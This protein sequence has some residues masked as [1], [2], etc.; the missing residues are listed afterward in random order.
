ML[1]RRVPQSG[2]PEPRHRWPPDGELTPQ[3][4]ADAAPPAGDEILPQPE[5]YPGGDDA[6]IAGNGDLRGRVTT[7][8]TVA[9]ANGTSG[10]GVAGAGRTSCDP[11]VPPSGAPQ[12]P[13]PA[14]DPSDPPA[15]GPAQAPSDTTG[16]KPVSLVLH[17]RPLPAGTTPRGTLVRGKTLVPSRHSICLPAW[18]GQSR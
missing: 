4:A 16:Q 3:A 10:N 13:C 1:I 6:Q 17:R 11:E 14:N 2:S 9:P 15:L 8:D 5:N 12:V 18:R 7:A